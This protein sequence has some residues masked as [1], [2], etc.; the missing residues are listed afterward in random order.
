MDWLEIVRVVGVI[1]V[2][3]CLICDFA[4]LFSLRQKHKAVD[5]L[6]DEAIEEM[7][8]ANE[9]LMVANKIKNMYEEKYEIEELLTSEE[10]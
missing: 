2:W 4:L 10:N 9:M 6:F 7:K 8:L 5:K 3:V 1:L